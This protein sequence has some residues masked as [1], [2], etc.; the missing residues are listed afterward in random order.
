[1][2]M[3]IQFMSMIKDHRLYIAYTCDY[4]A[5][6]HMMYLLNKSAFILLWETVDSLRYFVLLFYSLYCVIIQVMKKKK[7]IR[8]IRTFR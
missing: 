7:N 8:T 3:F 5:S 1:M 6:L 4:K 2:I